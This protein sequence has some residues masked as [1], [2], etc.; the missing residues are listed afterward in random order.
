VRIS[1]NGQ[2]YSSSSVPFAIYQMEVL[3]SVEPSSDFLGGGTP[4]SLSGRGFLNTT[5]LSCRFG[6]TLVRAHFE[7]STKLT[8]VS[9]TA[10]AAG[11]VSVEVSNNGVDF[12]ASTVLYT[13]YSNFVLAALEPNMAWR[14]GGMEVLISG[15]NFPTDALS[16]QCVFGG[17]GHSSPAVVVSSS[18]V[19]CPAPALPAHLDTEFARVT[20]LVDG[21]LA[22]TSDATFL[23]LDVPTVTGLVPASG[24]ETGGWPIHIS[25]Y[26]PA[27]PLASAHC[28]FSQGASVTKVTADVRGSTLECTVPRLALGP[29]SVAMSYNGRDYVEAGDIELLPRVT[30]SACTPSVGQVAGNQTIVLS[31][32]SLDTEGLCCSVDGTLSSIGRVD[33]TTATCTT[34]RHAAGSVPVGVVYCFSPVSADASM[35]AFDYVDGVV[36]KSFSPT[37]GRVEGGTVVSIVGAGFQR[38]STYTCF[39]GDDEV[40]ASYISSSALSCTVPASNDTVVDSRLV[41]FSVAH[42]ASIIAEAHFAYVVPPTV[43]SVYPVTGSEMGGSQVKVSVADGSLVGFWATMC[44]F[45]EDGVARA[46]VLVQESD[47]D[48]PSASRFAKG[49]SIFC[50]APAAMPGAVKLFLSPN[51]DDFFPVSDQ[52]ADFTYVPEPRVLSVEPVLVASSTK[53]VTLT[54]TSLNVDTTHACCLFGTATA[55]LLHTSS[56]TARC[57]VPDR[58]AVMEVGTTVDVAVSVNCRD[59]P[60]VSGVQVTKLHAAGPFFALPS[61]GPAHGGTVVVLSGAGIAQHGVHRVL[62]A[63]GDV[64]VPSQ[65]H[66]EHRISCVAP[67]VAPAV[68]TTYTSVPVSVSVDG[69][70]SF[71]PVAPGFF[72]SYASPAIVALEP[73]VAVEA[74]AFSLVVSGSGF[75]LPSDDTSVSAA[76]STDAACR[77]GTQS[78]RA[79]V[80]DDGTLLC[81]MAQLAAVPGTH[82]VAVSMNGQDFAAAGSLTVLP[83]VQGAVLLRDT[84]MIGGNQDISMEMEMDTGMLAV[85]RDEALLCSVDDSVTR[86]RI[87]AVLPGGKVLLTCALDVTRA[88]SYS[89]N[90][91]VAASGQTLL[92]NALQLRVLAPAMATS[93]EPTSITAGTDTVITLHGS[94]DGSEFYTCHFLL[95]GDVELSATPVLADPRK[96][97]CP[98]QHEEWS[99]ALVSSTATA[100]HIPVGVSVQSGPVEYVMAL[101]LLR[102]VAVTGVAPRVLLAGEAF[103]VTVSGAAFRDTGLVGC[104]VGDLAFPAYRVS[105]SE[106]VCNA[107]VPVPD[108]YSVAVTVDGA[109]FV[110][111]PA[112]VSVVEAPSGLTASSPSSVFPTCPFSGSAAGFVVRGL[113]LD[114]F[115]SDL[116]CTI[117][118]L[119]LAPT[120]VLDD[121]VTCGCP[122]LQSVLGS[123]SERIELDHSPDAT[124]RVSFSVGLAGQQSPLLAS[125][126]SYYASPVVTLAEGAGRVRDGESSPVNVIFASS[127][128]HLEQVTCRTRPLGA[129]VDDGEG[130]ASYLSSVVVS[131][132][133]VACVVRCFGTDPADQHVHLLLDVSID[134][135]HFIEVGAVTCVEPPVLVDTSGVPAVIPDVGGATVELTVEN[136]SGGDVDCLFG[137]TTGSPVSVT[138]SSKT[139]VYLA[140]RDDFYLRLMCTAPALPIGASSVSVAVGTVVSDSVPFRV[141]ATPSINLAVQA[142]RVRLAVGV[143]TLHVPMTNWDERLRD[144]S[145]CRVD[146]SRLLTTDVAPATHASVAHVLGCDL[147]RHVLSAG[148]H[149]LEVLSGGVVLGTRTFEIF[150]VAEPITMRPSAGLATGGTM[151]FIET[152]EIAVD[153]T[154]KCAFDQAIVSAFVVDKTTV[155][156]PTPTHAAA[157]H[158]RNAVVQLQLLEGDHASST[159]LPF[160]YV[161]PVT[162]DRVSPSWGAVTGGTRVR[163]EG[164]GFSP[165]AAYACVFG[166]QAPVPATLARGS[167]L[168]CTA[169]PSTQVGSSP[170][171]VTVQG[172]VVS[173]PNAATFEFTQ[174]PIFGAVEPASVSMH[175]GERV[176]LFASLGAV[177][178]GATVWCLFGNRVVTGL[179]KPGRVE[180]VAPPAPTA[181]QVS[182]SVSLNGG[183]YYPSDATA[184]MHINYHARVEVHDV[185]PKRG[186][187]TGGTPVTVIGTG[188]PDRADLQC[189]FGPFASFATR[190]DSS[191]LLCLVPQHSEALPAYT[192]AHV[193]MHITFGN[194]RRHSAFQ[195]QYTG[196]MTITGLAPARVSAAPV[197]GSTLVLTGDGFTD[198]PEKACRI[199]TAVVEAVTLSNTQVA[200]LMPVALSPGLANVALSENG[201][202]FVSAGALAVQAEL[203]LLEV[204]PM[205]GWTDGYTHVAIKASGLDRDSDYLCTFNG[206]S[207]IATLD[208]SM[209]VRCQTPPSVAGVAVVELSVVGAAVTSKNALSF[210]F[211]PSLVTAAVVPLVGPADATNAASVT[212]TLTAPMLGALPWNAVMQCAVMV[213]GGGRLVGD[214]TT[215]DVL[216]N[217]LTCAL[218]AIP[219]AIGRVRLEVSCNAG[220]DWQGVGVWYTTYV[221]PSKAGTTLT[222]SR[223]RQG[224]LTDVLVSLAH[225]AGGENRV[226]APHVDWQCSSS[227]G[228]TAHEA[229]ARWLT[230]TTV[231]CP[232]LFSGV[233]VGIVSVSG[234]GVS[235]VELGAV[236]VTSPPLLL[237]MTPS[238]VHWRGGSTVALS[239]YGFE[240]TTASVFSILLRSTTSA[241]EQRVVAHRVSDTRLELIM[242]EWAPRATPSADPADESTDIV[243]VVIQSGGLVSNAADAYS[244]APLLLAVHETFTPTALT[245]AFGLRSGAGSLRVDL[246]GTIAPDLGSVVEFLLPV[247]DGMTTVSAIPTTTISI[248]SGSQLLV[249]IPAAVATTLPA[250]ETVRSHVRVRLTNGFVSDALPFTF[251]PVLAAPTMVPSSVPEQGGPVTIPLAGDLPIGSGT[252]MCRFEKY[253][254]GHTDVIAD[255]FDASAVEC[256]APAGGFGATRVSITPNGGYDW[257]PVSQPLQYA[258]EPKPVALAPSSGGLAGSTEVV[259]TGVSLASLDEQSAGAV[260]FCRF[261]AL[262]VPALVRAVAEGGDSSDELVCITPRAMSAGTVDVALSLRHPLGGRRVP[263]PL[264]LFFAYHE[265]ATVNMLEPREAP[266]SGGAALVITGA[267]FQ[268]SPLLTVR[269]SVVADAADDAAGASVDVA[270]TY[271][272]PTVLRVQVPA[273]PK[274]SYMTFGRVLVSNNGVDFNTAAIPFYWTEGLLVHS[275]SPSR[276]FEEGGVLLT[277]TGET[278]SQSFPNVLGCRFSSPAGFRTVDG[279]YVSRTTMKCLAPALPTGQSEVFVTTNGQDYVAAGVLEVYPTPRLLSVAPS[280]GGWRGHTEVTAAVTGMTG[281]GA[282]ADVSCVFGV[283]SVPAVVSAD[284]GTVACHSPGTDR[285]TTGNVAFSLRV[286][287]D[288]ASSSTDSFVVRGTELVFTYTR[289]AYVHDASPLKGPAVGGTVV[290]L[291]G[292]FEHFV[293]TLGCVFGASGVVNATYLSGSQVLCAAP[294]SPLTSGSGTVA[295]KITSNGRAQ[296]AELTGVFFEYEVMPSFLSLGPAMGSTRGGTHVR[297][298]TTA[299]SDGP[300]Y[301]RLGFDT[302][303][304][305]AARVAQNTLDFTTPS[306]P[307]G[308]VDVA[309]S[310]NGVDYV[311]TGFKFHSHVG[312]AVLASS[313]ALGSVH[314]GTLVVVEGVNL[315]PSPLWYC[316]FDAQVAVRGSYSAKNTVECTAPAKGAINGGTVSLEVYLMSDTTATRLEITPS[317]LEY[318]TRCSGELTFEYVEPAQLLSVYPVVVFSSGGTEVTVAGEEL[319]TTAQAQLQCLW[320]SGG[321]SLTTPATLTAT[322]T[323][324]VCLTP[325]LEVGTANLT[326]TYNGRLETSADFLSVAVVAQ[327]TVT[328]SFPSRSVMGYNSTLTVHGTGFYKHAPKPQC[329]FTADG[330]DDVLAMATATVHSANAVT[331]NVPGPVN[332]AREVQTVTVHGP[333]LTAEVQAVEVVA[334]P[335]QP[336]V[337]RVAVEDWG[338]VREEWTLAARVNVAAGDSATATLTVKT[339]RQDEVQRI[340]LKPPA[341]Q[342]EQQSLAITVQAASIFEYKRQQED[343]GTMVLECG[344]YSAQLHWN[345][346]A[347][348]VQSALLDFPTVLAVTVTKDVVTLEVNEQ[349]RYVRQKITYDMTFGPADGDVAQVTIRDGSF[350]VPRFEA[351]AEVIAATS[352][353][354]IR[355]E[356]QEVS[357]VN[358]IGGTFKLTYLEYSTPRL[359]H[360]VSAAHFR[361]AMIASFPDVD[362]VHVSKIRDEHTQH[363]WQVTFVDNPGRQPPLGIDGELLK[364]A[365]EGDAGAWVTEVSGGEVVHHNQQMVLTETGVGPRTLD[366]DASEIDIIGNAPSK[367]SG[368]SITVAPGGRYREWLITFPGTQGDYDV[369][370]YEYPPGNTAEEAVEVLKGAATADLTDVGG[371]VSLAFAPAVGDARMRSVPAFA[372]ASL[373]EDAL[374]FMGLGDTSVVRSDGGNAFASWTYDITFHELTTSAD[375]GFLSD[376]LSVDSSGMEVLRGQGS[377]ILAVTREPQAACCLSANSFF[378]TGATK[379]LSV[380]S[381]AAVVAEA[382]VHAAA[383][384][385][386]DMVSGVDFRVSDVLDRASGGRSWTVTALTPAFDMSAVVV[387]DG[388]VLSLSGGVAGADTT[389]ELVRT[390]AP[391]IAEVQRLVIN[392][393]SSENDGR[394]TGT[395]TLSLGGHT[396]L[397]IPLDTS[398]NRLADYISSGLY[399]DMVTV[400]AVHLNTSTPYAGSYRVWDVEFT[401]IAGALNELLTCDSS[402]TVTSG[403]HMVACSAT[404]HQA[405]TSV[406]AAGTFKL[407]TAPEGVFTET[408]S[409]APTGSAVDM[410]AQIEALTGVSVEVNKHTF[411]FNSVEWL[412]TYTGLRGDEP[413]LYVDSSTMTG[414]SATATSSEQQRGSYVGGYFTLS[415][416]GATTAPLAHNI[417]AYDLERALL[418]LPEVE[419][420]AVSVGNT[421]LGRRYQVTFVEPAGDVQLIQ[422]DASL[423]EGTEATVRVYERIRGV[424]SLQGQFKLTAGGGAA[425]TADTTSFVDVLASAAELKA[426][427]EQLPSVGEVSVSGPDYVGSGYQW[428]VTYTTMGQPSNAGQVPL[429]SAGSL[430]PQDGK[431]RVSTARAKAGCCDVRLSYNGGHETARATAA[432]TLD[433]LPSVVA[434]APTSGG[435]N[436]GV[437]VVVTGSGFL[438]ADVTG[439]DFKAVCLFGSLSAPAVIVNS[440]TALCTAPPHPAA[441]VAV[442]LK[443]NSVDISAGTSEPAIARSTQTFV[444]EPSLAL[445]YA[446]PVFG[447]IDQTTVVTLV[448][449]A[450]LSPD[451]E[452]RCRWNV[453]L[454]HA[455][456]GA[457]PPTV[458]DMPASRLNDTFLTCETP[459]TAAAYVDAS[460]PDW[461]LDSNATATVSVTK[462]LQT[463]S[464]EVDFFFFSRPIVHSIFP[465]VAVINGGTRL[466]VTG[467][468]FV[469]NKRAVCRIGSHTMSAV[470][471]SATRATCVTRHVDLRA[472]VHQVRVIGPLV[473]NEVQ[474]VE[475]WSAQRH[476]LS[477]PL[478]GHIRLLL[479]GVETEPIDIGT[480]SNG[481]DNHDVAAN[482]QAALEVLPRVV[483]ATVTHSF[484]EEVDWARGYK[485]NVSAYAVS[486]DARTDNVPAMVVTGQLAADA[487]QNVTGRVEGDAFY[488]RTLVGGGSDVSS[489]EVQHWRFTQQRYTREVQRVNISAPLP[490]QEEQYVTLTPHANEAGTFTLTYDG[491]SSPPISHDAP[492]SVVEAALRAA[493]TLG[494]IKVSYEWTSGDTHTWSVT[495]RDV[496]G[497]RLAIIADDTDLTESTSALAV[498]PGPVGSEPF[499]GFFSL[500]M[501]GTDQRTMN[502]SVDAS[503]DM[504]HTAVVGTFGLSYADVEVRLISD[505]YSRSWTITFPAT[506]GDIADLVTSASFVN[507]TSAAASVEELVPGSTKLGGAYVLGVLGEAVN[508]NVADT[509]DEL[510]LKIQTAVSAQLPAGTIVLV[511]QV[512]GETSDFIQG[513][514]ITYPTTAIDVPLLVVST[515]PVGDEL[516]V[517]TAVVSKGSYMP[518]G[519]FFSLSVDGEGTSD[520]PHTASAQDVRNELMLLPTVNNVTVLQRGG[521][522]VDRFGVMYKGREWNISFDSVIREHY[523]GI[524]DVVLHNTSLTGRDSLAETRELAVGHGPF[525]PVELSFDGQHFT[526]SRRLLEFVEPLSLLT[527]EPTH[528]PNGGGTV[529]TIVVSQL[530]RTMRSLLT[531]DVRCVFGPAEVP[532]RFVSDTKVQC[533]TPP[534]HNLEGGETGVRL[535]L[536]NQDIS[537]DV[538]VFTHDPATDA[539]LLAPTFGTILGATV[540]NITGSSIVARNCTGFCAFDDSVVPA[541]LCADGL[542]TCHTPPQAFARQAVVTFSLN[543]V[544]YVNNT[545]LRFDYVPQPT[546]QR[547][548]PVRGAWSGGTVVRVSGASFTMGTDLTQCRFGDIVVPSSMY[549]ATTLGCVAPAL[550]RAYEVQALESSLMAFQ[551]NVHVLT[552]STPADVGPLIQVKASSLPTV[553]RK[554]SFGVA[555]TQMAETQSVKVGVNVTPRKTAMFNVRDTGRLNAKQRVFTTFSPPNEVQY[556]FLRTSFD[557]YADEYPEV[558]SIVYSGADTTATIS[559]TLHNAAITFTVGDSQATVQSNLDANV[560]SGVTVVKAATSD[561]WLWTVQYPLTGGTSIVDPVSASV[562]SGA[563]SVVVSV[564]SQG[565]VA[566]VQEIDFGT[567]PTSGTVQ[568]GFWPFRDTAAIDVLADASEV[569]RK[570]EAV[571]AIGKVAVTIS[572]V[573]TRT[574]TV[575]FRQLSGDVDPVVLTTVGLA[576]T[577]TVTEIVK[578]TTQRLTGTYTL[579]RSG[580]TTG[581][582]AVS[583]TNTTFI[584]Q[585]ITS[586]F[587]LAPT[588][589]SVSVMSLINDGVLLK[590]ETDKRFG[591]VPEITVGTDSLSATK[592]DASVTTTTQGSSM[593]G[594][595]RVVVRTVNGQTAT[596]ELQFDVSGADMAAAL[597]EAAPE[598]APFTV[599][600]SDGSE[601]GSFN[602]DIIFPFTAG[603]VRDLATSAA[604]LS[605]KGARGGVVVQRFGRVATVQKISTSAS[606]QLS[607]FFTLSFEGAS[608]ELLPHDITPEAL[609]M[610]LRKMPTMG[611]IEVSRESTGWKDY[612]TWDTAYGQDGSIEPDSPG[613]E[614]PSPRLAHVASLFKSDLQTYDWRVTFISRSGS[615][616]DIPLF[617]ACCSERGDAMVDEKE[618]ITLSSQWSRD[619]RVTVAHDVVGTKIKIGGEV[620]LGFGSSVTQYMPIT[621][622]AANVRDAI[623]NNVSV[624]RSIADEN[625]HYSWLVDYTYYTDE[626]VTEDTSVPFLTS[627]NAI[628]LT[629]LGN[630]LYPTDYDGLVT[631]DWADKVPMHEI[632]RLDFS[633]AAAGQTATCTLDGV[634]VATITNVDT[635]DRLDVQAAFDAGSLAVQVT[636]VE[637][638]AFDLIFTGLAGDVNPLACT[639]AT[640]FEQQTGNLELLGGTFSLKFTMRDG[641]TVTTDPIAARASHTDVQT[642]LNAVMGAGQVRVTQVES[643]DMLTEWKVW[644]EGALVSGNV[645][646]LEIEWTSLNGTNPFG[647]VR[648]IAP[649]NQPAGHLRVVNA[650]AERLIDVSSSPE[651][652]AA[653]LKSLLGV[654]EV[655]VAITEPDAG[656]GITWTIEHSVP[657]SNGHDGCL[658]GCDS[659]VDYAAFNITGEYV[660]AVGKTT[661]MQTLHNGTVAFAGG[662]AVSF[663]A[664]PAVN[665]TAST[666]MNDLYQSLVK[667]LPETFLGAMVSGESTDTGFLFNI[668]LGLDSDRAVRSIPTWTSTPYLAGTG[669]TYSVS[670]DR[671]SA[672]LQGNFTLHFLGN[673]SLPIAAN[674]TALE[675]ADALSDLRNVTSVTVTKD[676][677]RAFKQVWRISFTSL[678]DVG[679]P[680]DETF[681]LVRESLFA[682]DVA[683]TATSTGVGGSLTV[684]R[685]AYYTA[686]SSDVHFLD[687][688]HGYSFDVSVGGVSVGTFDSDTLATTMRSAVEASPLVAH[689][690]VERV[691]VSPTLR[692]WFVL[693]VPASADVDP[694][695]AP[696]VEVELSGSSADAGFSYS[697]SSTMTL[698][699]TLDGAEVAGA[700]G[701]TFHEPMCVN[702]P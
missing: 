128:G 121:A 462:N 598:L 404:V 405:A 350:K 590:V 592:L 689:A 190:L 20:L 629:F 231:V 25:L 195:Y 151:I 123:G 178:P 559:V 183:D 421:P 485:W 186:P 332:M 100:D 301:V 179:V 574:W 120:S 471:T 336:E 365:N 677:D 327:P 539:L 501:L 431:F 424:G 29:A 490:V 547:I 143:H 277:L 250:N 184:Q 177:Q 373:M 72:V 493:G 483:A 447:Q 329:L 32:T 639:A 603:D 473:L 297:M 141:V 95:P 422:A 357:V 641:S 487:Q 664:A 199:G 396:T 306:L 304:V 259:I 567:L 636:E 126:I 694:F 690:I 423:L 476:P 492:A 148:V 531:Y 114:S 161:S 387:T 356:L 506:S 15:E 606:S 54:G 165:F 97:M 326:I 407:R 504:V 258:S 617:S 118:H 619:S 346:S 615:T 410:Q 349:A 443:M 129:S 626:T 634:P 514:R 67:A 585:E 481:Q 348:E 217:S 406:A 661:T 667:A 311:E 587:G 417:P 117:G 550:K 583:E 525:L 242:P 91:R 308:S 280:L 7:S 172:N 561:G 632:Q 453:S 225:A 98:V 35:V 325:E 42:N 101:T 90:V 210:D 671:G 309:F 502:L 5:D 40:L 268:D 623:G 378:L 551:P 398:Q 460:Q 61:R 392:L 507:G 267:A 135:V 45:G 52:V 631:W 532:A 648:E 542:M 596:R 173:P 211:V 163:L 49:W 334:L 339:T 262:E 391:A 193:P 535:V 442:S 375:M 640:N 69:G 621:A 500:G 323:R 659:D 294:P 110:E 86:A 244:A 498:V 419:T 16:V 482:I 548:D 652:M 663:D 208:A 80:K 430:E 113:A 266:S 235:W 272:S 131:D 362:D 646:S 695:S 560:L 468:N 594:V 222:P 333:A 675:L 115:S 220:A 153:G 570:L 673:D 470:V 537:S 495:F 145:V 630:R 229:P 700:V 175:G 73:P 520:M 510:R 403:P 30:V 599:T 164:S 371:W 219:R 338:V 99:S 665:F 655:S 197:L 139:S 610:A 637:D 600:R 660:N 298:Q 394:L 400:R 57:A 34:H 324:Y 344:Y 486:F 436:G 111:A 180:C 174:E 66:S 569:K 347:L 37:S 427:L 693:A 425:D 586:S 47:S 3:S 282:A 156:C 65:L 679:L 380:R 369:L 591:D 601:I 233:G 358:A 292:N 81:R 70:H 412:V 132:D 573:P 152:T 24:S 36:V 251:F 187:A 12:S 328:G 27:S 512:D 464:N 650:D 200:C 300:A 62:C 246:D 445:H 415:F 296:D 167:A 562:S 275:L 28:R 455:G 465:S 638:R 456:M 432:I 491:S 577:P 475:V 191:R 523:E 656:G 198:S 503:A 472:P 176:K 354:G 124:Y 213:K 291:R 625:S 63:F 572:T 1:S 416:G 691:D 608:T 384:S 134:G 554:Y 385:G 428:A 94:F 44:R 681:S 488:V 684:H 39:I 290:D 59:A 293:G 552:V 171:L 534:H 276:T 133:T 593:Y 595:F 546:V 221:Q 364:S 189:V 479:E 511:D 658:V 265:E 188:F 429:L 564:A 252:V 21:R 627:R 565:G 89:V 122:N 589:V 245:P 22:G 519:G 702:R 605:G 105:T 79:I 448:T 218:P 157:N 341:Y 287:V 549:S 256:V 279:L 540:V 558:H 692:E 477:P 553:M 411:D 238:A 463:F 160:V 4:V 320:H 624:T 367:I 159:S 51:G 696:I 71:L 194:Q 383:V 185:V 11:Q 48:R 240:Q 616:A 680:V 166:G 299:L 321:E 158:G 144:G 516:D 672:P 614:L 19:R 230:N 108:T 9:P 597:E 255:H 284:G 620:A 146:G 642:E 102:E 685:F 302:P 78:V 314:G 450:L 459:A 446:S 352:V 107:T 582:I 162:I 10:S 6:D 58:W 18:E 676:V 390:R 331:C 237:G 228:V 202:D 388:S 168:T 393:E 239:G 203:L 50:E 313:P 38:S 653:S 182:I 342:Q 103:A 575:T 578:G 274:G 435:T 687:V 360:D 644:F 580:M 315:F 518:L 372:S 361:E 494:T 335:S 454:L 270:A 241:Y 381:E 545:D 505:V 449:S 142:D 478:G 604:G 441:R 96:V 127:M 538:M 288:G 515:P 226:F 307:V 359:Q 688:S 170:L 253:S 568:I 489:T 556:V 60:P 612:S 312:P 125:T 74:A 686:N 43:R 524:I 513:W 611:E 8:C 382:I 82:T 345:A 683:V 633:S 480:V 236:E 701:L 33:G 474:A 557:A 497:P 649:G 379:P 669:L 536:N 386:T 588:D 289:S 106:V 212:V 368:V 678:K 541:D 571:A 389:V 697:V 247:Q 366:I 254:G 147:S 204:T 622:L 192:T 14:S 657:Q 93:V 355:C 23:F 528:G 216:T 283:V 264:P 399:L 414:T 137:S 319:S 340:V 223:M 628:A 530:H 343:R 46:A 13:Y 273:N 154:Y 104:R 281:L 112:S 509:A 155:A 285:N 437:Q 150:A 227:I 466:Q 522:T 607:G 249:A 645:P 496:I 668:T 140:A 224:V 467:S 286:S 257:I 271:V 196:P 440:T 92:A 469:R 670:A 521:D 260:P 444:F 305:L 310:R 613:G 318:A 566:E 75:L 420:L 533:T 699:P 579:S 374:R 484:R 206:V 295:I 438:A 544:D 31:G 17:V 234:N 635:A 77:I 84:M 529:I 647:V 119:K 576:V 666:S 395:F 499:G 68:N 87:Q 609:A 434:L 408:A 377:A 116:V 169:P 651:S 351:D 88:G 201:V 353:S 527:I 322:H 363:R 413:T 584:R 618:D 439:S 555:V 248:D 508:V 401:S 397:Q 109:T 517:H 136:P 149:E 232:A 243:Q 278:F 654:E 316:V 130:Q 207:T 76:A 138:P 55:P 451:D 64:T 643:S 409:L 674:A 263:V 53:E 303:I 261:G 2:Q 269:F 458:Y 56:E 370:T 418:E 317:I 214:V 330:S 85:L 181:G 433:A 602:W 26:A 205:V 41:V 337:Q 543:G 215:V 662:L 682:E 209:T 452:L 457:F 526:E 563:G 461:F 581:D 402:G 426:H 698:Q 83:R 376:A